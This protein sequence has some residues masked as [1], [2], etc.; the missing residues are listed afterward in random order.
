MPRAV[1][2]AVVVMVREW[3]SSAEAAGDGSVVNIS[4]CCYVDVA[5]DMSVSVRVCVSGLVDVAD[6]DAPPV[7]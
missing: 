4:S 7:P 5:A 3:A 6:P 1:A 2:V